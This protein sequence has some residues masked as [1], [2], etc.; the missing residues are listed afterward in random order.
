MAMSYYDPLLAELEQ[1]DQPNYLTQSGQAMSMRGAPIRA[2]GGFWGNLAQQIVPGLLG[3]GMSYLGQQQNRGEQDALL[4]AAKLED[5]Q[6]IAASLEAG[7]YKDTAAK[8]LFAAQAERK[9]QE[10][11]Y[12]AK[13]QEFKDEYDYKIEPK[14]KLDMEKYNAQQQKIDSRAGAKNS[15]MLE[16]ARITAG[17][18]GEKA[19]RQAELQFIKDGN[20]L[21]AVQ[22]VNKTAPMVQSL[23]NL[24]SEAEKRGYATG[25]E[26][27]TAYNQAGRASSDEALNDS[28]IRALMASEGFQGEIEQFVGWAANKGRVSPGL[29]RAMS[30]ASK[31]TQ[32]GRE[33]EAD[34]QIARLASQYG[35]ITKAPERFDVLKPSYQKMAQAIAPEIMKGPQPAQMPKTATSTGVTES[36]IHNGELWEKSDGLWY[37]RGKQ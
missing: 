9:A 22:L 32:A 2:G 34:Q 5:P 13:I 4:A 37:N 16:A 26:A 30:D 10:A 33:V 6:A 27:I 19:L 21:P 23:D 36:K 1:L 7:G 14:H 3:A 11:A 17:A 8:V 31:K 24:A 18:E 20:Q 25:A 29:I 15:T 12:K 28:N 35:T